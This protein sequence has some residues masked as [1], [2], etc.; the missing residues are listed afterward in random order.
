VGIA[1]RQ[2]HLR[3]RRLSLALAL[4]TSSLIVG[5]AAHAAEATTAAGTATAAVAADASPQPV[6]V[7]DIV[8]TAQRRSESLQKTPVA[9][10]AFGQDEVKTQAISTFRDLSGRVPGL[11]APRRSTAYTTQTYAVRGIGE[12]D[13]YPEPAV[14]V[15]VDDVYLA[16]T[17]GSNYD[18]PDLERVEVLRGPQGTL[19]GRNS[20]AGAI[21]YITKDPASVLGG[22]LGVTYGNYNNVEIKGRITGPILADDKLDGSIAFDRHSRDGWTDAVNIHQWV[23]NL[24][25]T[26]VRGKL[27]SQITP[28]FTATLSFDGMLDRSSQSYYTPVNQPNGLSTGARTNPDITYSNALPYNRTEAYGAYLTLKY[29]LTGQLSLKSVTAVRGMNGP[30]YYDNDGVTQVKGDSYAGFDENFRTQELDLN[31]EYDRFNFVAGLYYFYEYFD[32]DRFGQSAS[33]PVDNIGLVTHVHSYLRTESYAAFGQ[34]NYKITPKLTLTVGGRYTVDNRTFLAYGQSQNGQPLA[35]NQ[36]DPTLWQ[37]RFNTALPTYTAFTA[38]D[39]WISF[40]SFTPKAALEYQWTGDLLTY[41]T[42][43]QGFKSGGYDLR[44]TTL[45]AA[46]AHYLPQTTTAYELG[47]KSKLF[48]GRLTADTAIYYNQIHDL[49][50][51]ATDLRNGTNTLINTGD[52]H[53]AG[54]EQEFAAVPLE[55]LKLTASAAYLYTHY[56]TFTAKLPANAAGRTTLLGLDFPFAP[57]WTGGISAVYRLPFNTTGD[58]KLAADAQYESKRYSDIYDTQQVEV[59]AQTFVNASLSYTTADALWTGGIS[60]KNLFNLQQNQAG[61]YSPANAGAQP[62]WYYAFNEPRF[63]N[64]SLTRKF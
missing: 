17:V 36:T 45:A 24:D 25:L 32:N 64:V 41:F 31:G 46:T 40:A 23:N 33:S 12:I 9:V 16:R 7:G 20:S 13:T 1:V 43:S 6:T 62:L 10:T 15:Y 50:E 60:V 57:H 30:I 5:S 51:R 18:T 3:Q 39:P 29:D 55:G 59:N 42:F 27:K 8:V 54:V 63:V 56:D 48:D 2:N 47:L 37:A 28:K 35:D 14:A 53:T 11:L 52:G 49:Q 19:Y 61:G 34:V 38:R 22:E 21:R 4:T 26:A 44:A 58:W